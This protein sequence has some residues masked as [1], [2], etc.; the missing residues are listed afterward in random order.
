[1]EFLVRRLL[2]QPKNLLVDTSGEGSQQTEDLSGIVGQ[3]YI[4]IGE[5]AQA[6]A[7]LVSDAK[8]WLSGVFCGHGEGF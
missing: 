4:S 6:A 1:M 8:I 5:A 3:A 7:L 2:G